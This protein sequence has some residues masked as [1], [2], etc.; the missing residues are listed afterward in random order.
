MK[1]NTILSLLILIATAVAVS[2]QD[3]KGGRVL[4]VKYDE[5]RYFLSAVTESGDSVLFYTDTGGGLFIYKHAA[6]RLN[7]LPGDGG[8]SIEFPRFKHG[9]EIPSPLATEGKIFVFPKPEKGPPLEFDAML[10]QQWFADRIWTFDYPGKRLLVWDKSPK[11]VKADARHVVTLGFKTDDGGKRV[12]HFPRIQAEIDGEVLEMLFDTGATTFLTE[13]ALTSLG[14]KRASARAASFI[15]SSRFEKWR[16][17]HPDWRVIEAAEIGS[18]QAMIEAR[19][20]RIAGFKV[21]RAWFTR[22][23]DKNFHEYMSSFM[24]KRVDGAIGGTVLNHFKV[25]VDYPRA[26]AVFEKR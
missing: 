17:R 15:S 23:P 13:A 11:N 26:I 3:S 20:I 18:G 9:V 2:A 16:H 25:T 6:E 12:L 22:R 10:G 5:D 8:E 4:P 19:D 1:P 24:D 21:E 7:L 14:D